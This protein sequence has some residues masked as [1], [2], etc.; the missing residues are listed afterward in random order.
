MVRVVRQPCQDGL[1]LYSNFEGSGTALCVELQLRNASSMA[2]S[3]D[4]EPLLF[5]NSSEVGSQ[6]QQ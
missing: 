2:K 5:W 4:R 1:Q 3:V 6:G